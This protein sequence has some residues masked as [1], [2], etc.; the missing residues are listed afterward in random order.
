MRSTTKSI[1]SPRHGSSN[2]S[3]LDTSHKEPS[4]DEAS[5]NSAQPMSSGPVSVTSS[6]ASGCGPTL[7]DLPAFQTTPTSG[8]APV[9][10]NRSRPRARGAERATLDIFGQQRARRPGSD[11]NG[12]HVATHHAASSSGQLNP[13][14]SRWLMGLPRAWDDCAVTATQS[15]QKSP[16]RSSRQRSK[17][18]GR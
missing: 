12:S 9:R 2:S 7:F 13:A 3:L 17:R 14:H 5:P 11:A 10:A 8:P 1:R 6:Q 4:N 16:P 15:S 18:G